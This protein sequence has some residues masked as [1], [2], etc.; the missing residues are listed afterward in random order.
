MIA[1]L[2]AVLFPVL[3]SAALTAFISASGPLPA[4]HLA[5]ETR[6]RTV[7]ESTKQ[8]GRTAEPTPVMVRRWIQPSLTQPGEPRELFCENPGTEQDGRVTLAT[9]EYVDHAGYV[10]LGWDQGDYGTTRYLVTEIVPV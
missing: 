4:S 5:K 8:A 9:G 3:L 2:C 1:I 10:F 6:E 7:N